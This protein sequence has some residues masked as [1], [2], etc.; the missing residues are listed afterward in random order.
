MLLWGSHRCW[1]ARAG[2][3][4]WLGRD[5]SHAEGGLQSPSSCAHGARGR[6]V[7][8]WDFVVWRAACGICCVPWG[9]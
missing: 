2:G 9:C 8:T 7:L 1:E 4:V 5:A 3:S 6:A